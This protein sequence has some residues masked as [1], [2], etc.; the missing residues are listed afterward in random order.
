[1]NRRTLIT[2]WALSLVTASAAS[3]TAAGTLI[4]GRQVANGSLTN[5][6]VRDGSL[7]GVDLRNGSI[8]AIDLGKGVVKP[9]AIAAETKA[10]IVASVPPEVT[11]SAVIDG[12]NVA[13]VAGTASNVTGVQR[14]ATGVYCVAVAG[15]DAATSTPTA[16][17]DV[18][19][20]LP[21][22][23]V[24]VDGQMKA[25]K[26]LG[27]VAVSVATATCPAGIEVRTYRDIAANLVLDNSV[28]FSLAV[29]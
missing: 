15:I 21:P 25:R 20:S 10:D 16:T 12:P 6:D 18:A 5:A 19:R 22:G 2:L 7:T 24:E 3:A 1:M 8:G 28:A 9:R 13:I 26:D 4:T 27:S 23:T 29:L 11:A 14:V 17:M